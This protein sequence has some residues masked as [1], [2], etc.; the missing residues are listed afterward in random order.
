MMHKTEQLSAI[1]LR[2]T[3][4]GEAD[5]IL[6]LLTPQGRRDVIAKGA[7]RQHSKLAGGIELFAVC[8]VV[9]RSGRGDLGLLT[10]ARLQVFY[11]YILEDYERMQLAYRALQL[12]ARASQAID[13]PEWFAV[14]SQVLEQLNDPM[15]ELR[16]VES[17]LYLQH[18]R[19]LGDE[20]NLHH[21]VTG[22]PLVPDKQYMYDSTEQALRPSQQ[23]NLT[24][25]HIKLLRL[26]QTQPLAVITQVGGI[27]TVLPDC[28][29][30]AR[31]HAS[32]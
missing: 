6:Q 21:D 8:Q 4:Y 26:I 27:A 3:D 2:R 29:L 16:L 7:R 14:L 32:L 22:R 31:Q 28:W 25:E 20:L 24:T 9:V 10:S 12:I 18:H 13:E 5:R 23:G 1:V 17:W 11:R 15:V 30:T 19:L